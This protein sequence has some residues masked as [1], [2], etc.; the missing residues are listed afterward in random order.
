[1]LNK[2]E[3]SDNFYNFEVVQKEEAYAGLPNT[4]L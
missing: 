3:N 1:M 2:R 4:K